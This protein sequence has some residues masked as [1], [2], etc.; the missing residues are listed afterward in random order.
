MDGLG[1]LKQIDADQLSMSG[2]SAYSESQF[3]MSSGRSGMSGVSETSK[4]SKR[5]G[6]IK[7][8][9]KQKLRK[10]RQVKEGSPY[11]EASLIDML[12]EEVKITPA[13]KDEVRD[14]MRALLNFALVDESTEIHSLVEKV[15]KAQHAVSHLL[16]V[17]QQQFLE[18]A[19]SQQL[20]IADTFPEYF[21]RQKADEDQQK[22]LAE[23][24]DI[25]FFKH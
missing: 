21:G 8:Q 11:E 1:G 15:M 19:N 23:W 3:S 6:A 24:R 25:K 4:K 17:E 16:S 5:Q 22:A 9:Q 18:K 12:K 13:D 2:T 14:L 7:K 20:F 10:K